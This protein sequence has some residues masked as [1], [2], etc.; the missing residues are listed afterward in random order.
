MSV[1]SIQNRH[2][3]VHLEL[4]ILQIK[5][6]R[7]LKIY[8]LYIC[9]KYKMQQYSYIYLKFKTRWD[10]S[11]I[12]HYFKLNRISVGLW[13]ERVTIVVNDKVIFTVSRI[14]LQPCHVRSNYQFLAKAKAS[15]TGNRLNSLPRESAVTEL[16]SSAFNVTLFTF[17]TGVYAPLVRV[18]DVDFEY[19]TAHLSQRG[20]ST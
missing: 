2:S 7:M 9:I 20:Y 16:C 8:Y 4:K 13:I 15:G 14:V 3:F 1:L 17:R 6:R 12:S 18:F 5:T 10:T 11:L 19:P